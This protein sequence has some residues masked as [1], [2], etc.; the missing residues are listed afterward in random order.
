MVDRNWYFVIAAYSVAWVFILGYW[1]YV[2]RT[3]A[4]ARDRYERA[5]GA[6]REGP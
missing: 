3:V 4:Q 5:T 1:V 6:R 2:H